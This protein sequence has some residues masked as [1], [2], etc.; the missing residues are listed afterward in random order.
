MTITR[1]TWLHMAL[2]MADKAKLS[3]TERHEAECLAPVE[4]D[5]EAI[6]N[7]GCVLAIVSQRRVFSFPQAS[8]LLADSQHRQVPQVAA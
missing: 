4:A 1:V 6:V 5:G 8:D 2:R 7:A 3:L